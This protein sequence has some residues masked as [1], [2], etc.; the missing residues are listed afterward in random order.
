MSV[1][2]KMKT[3]SRP[4]DERVASVLNGDSYTDRALWQL[5]VILAEIATSSAPSSENPV[6]LDEG[7]EDG[8]EGDLRNE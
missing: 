6:A 8:N 1:N 4:R 3:A 2:Q 7:L 5:S